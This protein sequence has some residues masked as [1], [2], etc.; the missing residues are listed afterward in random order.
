[1]LPARHRIRNGRPFPICISSFTDLRQSHRP[2]KSFLKLIIIAPYYIRSTDSTLPLNLDFKSTGNGNF[3]HLKILLD[4]TLTSA[5][6]FAY[7]TNYAKQGEKMNISKTDRKIRADSGNP[8][9]LR[10]DRRSHRLQGETA[11]SGYIKNPI[12]GGSISSNACA[13]PVCRSNP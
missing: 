4:L 2:R 9:L 12:L 11:A 1:M 5:V 8:A 10:T 7:K 6:S 3:I 13:M